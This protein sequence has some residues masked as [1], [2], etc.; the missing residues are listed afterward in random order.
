[1]VIKIP[2]PTNAANAKISVGRG[3]AKYEPGE[4]ALVWR[5]SSFPGSTECLLAAIV[6][7]LP[8]TREKA[9]TRTPITMDFMIK[10]YSCSGVQVR[11]LKVYEKSGYQTARWVQY[12]SKSGEY[13]AKI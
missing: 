6:D 12:F 8:Q 13:S 2:V 11:F 10:M 3:R 4:R 7:L 5:I 9:W 1:V